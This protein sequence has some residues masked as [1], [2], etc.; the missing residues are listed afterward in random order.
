[1]YQEEDFVAA[2]QEITKRRGVDVVYDSVGQATF[3]KSL[4][5]L[6][7]MGTMVSFGQS[8][9]TVEPINV[10]L[11]GAKGSLFLTRPSLMHYTAARNNLI[12]HAKDLFEV[13]MSGAV[14]M[15]ILQEYAFK[16]AAQA[17]GDLE[18][19]K[20]S[21]STILLPYFFSGNLSMRPVHIRLRI[22][23]IML[24]Y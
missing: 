2:V 13:V 1:L 7:P 8:S 6:R 17:H 21:G 4:D 24:T 10:G 18:G 19:R 3:M 14:R 15:N 16:N 23:P 11:L 9:G 5:R 12:A 20:T 22:F